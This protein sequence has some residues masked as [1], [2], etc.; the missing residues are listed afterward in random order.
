MGCYRDASVCHFAHPH[1]RE[2][3]AA[4][5]SAPPRFENVGDS[6]SDP[7]YTLAHSDRRDREKEKRDRDRGRGRGKGRSRGRDKDKE[8]GERDQDNKYRTR[9]LRQDHAPST[10][11][12]RSMDKGREQERADLSSKTPLGVASHTPDTHHTV[13]SIAQHLLVPP[14]PPKPPPQLPEV[15]NVPSFVFT[16][17]PPS[18]AETGPKGLKELSMDE[19]RSAWHERIE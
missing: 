8:D 5:P 7:F 11:P 10:S 6:D 13:G 19:K 2:W 17:Q 15:P 9:D 18:S 14:V 12:S 16:Q 4:H 3:E 1:E